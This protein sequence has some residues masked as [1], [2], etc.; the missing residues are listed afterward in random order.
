[1]AKKTVSRHTK[2]PGG[3][4][5]EISPEEAGSLLGVHPRTI[6]NLL[7]RKE[8]LGLKSDVAQA[9]HSHHSRPPRK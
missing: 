7:A 5:K 9:S 2:V 4:D 8:L 1:M 6:R 3:K